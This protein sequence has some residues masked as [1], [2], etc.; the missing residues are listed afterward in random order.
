MFDGVE[1]ERIGDFGLCGGGAAGFELD[2]AD[3]RLGTPE[4][5]VVLARSEG[6]GEDVVLV[7]EEVLTH[8]TTIPGQPAEELLRADMLWHETPAGGAVFSVG[9]ITF[10]GALPCD[11]FDNDV[12]RL[13]GNVLGRMLGE[14]PP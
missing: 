9:S 6:H 2:R 1:S 5:A 3:T 14:A 13:L 12:S 10:C 4:D 11:D 8:L 7:P